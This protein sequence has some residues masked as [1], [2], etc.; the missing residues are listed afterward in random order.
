MKTTRLFALLFVLVLAA[1]MAFSMGKTVSAEENE[2]AAVEEEQDAGTT[3]GKAFAAALVVG[4]VGAAA[5]IGMA[6][7]V[8]K[9]SESMARQP[10]AA[11]RINS[12]MMLGLVFIE[13]VV[14]YALIVAILLI[15]VL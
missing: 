12:S 6:L 15:F 9:S 3:K 10:E 14:I 8:S 4:I 2:P 13:T 5:A 11:G 1:V 7:A